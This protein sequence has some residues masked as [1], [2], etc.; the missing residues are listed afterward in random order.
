[1][2]LPEMVTVPVP[3][4]CMPYTDWA[5]PEISDTE[6]AL[7]LL[8]VEVLP[9]VLLLMVVVPALL[10]LTIPKKLVGLQDVLAT[11]IAPMVLFRQSTTSVLSMLM[12]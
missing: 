4:L 12:P 9:M 10:D 2:V 6:L 3:A 7:M 1:M 5:L 11:V 8:A